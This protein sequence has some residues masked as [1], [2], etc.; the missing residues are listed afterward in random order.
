VVIS[1]VIGKL[2]L[3]QFLAPVYDKKKTVSSVTPECDDPRIS[4]RRRPPTVT[5]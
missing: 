2:E 4:V 3:Q 5:F 1:H